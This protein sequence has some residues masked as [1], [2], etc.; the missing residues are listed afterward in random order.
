[1]RLRP[2]NV[3]SRLTVWYVL[4]LAGLLALYAGVASLFRLLS[5][6]ED[7]DRNLVKDVEI[8]EGILAKEPGGTVSLHASH[9][10]AAEP[11]IGHYIEVLSPQGTV[12]YR[13]PALKDRNLG[14]PPDQ[15]EACKIQ[16]RLPHGFRMAPG[17]DSLV[18][19]IFVEDLK[20]GSVIHD[21][22][23]LPAEEQLQFWHEEFTPLA[24]EERA[25]R[26][27]LLLAGRRVSP[28]RR[29]Q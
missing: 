8:V 9:P 28:E 10:D 29:A 19:F 14:G 16:V 24:A 6:R 12:L 5:L 21:M 18:V 11:R 20:E 17:S 2:R 4:V 15:D 27:K 25:L 7:F 1:M 22:A 13:S 3:R 23:A 26:E